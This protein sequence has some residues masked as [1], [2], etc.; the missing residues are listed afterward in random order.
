MHSMIVF[1]PLNPIFRSS[2]LEILDLLTSEHRIKEQIKLSVDKL[3]SSSEWK[4][5]SSF[6]KVKRFGFNYHA[7]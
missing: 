5:S 4:T 3:V 7:W 1:S 6:S 2:I